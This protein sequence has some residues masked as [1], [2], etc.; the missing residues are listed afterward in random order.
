[1]PY[2]LQKMSWQSLLH[3]KMNLNISNF[4]KRI[5]LILGTEKPYIIL[6][7]T[8]IGGRVETTQYVTMAI[9]SSATFS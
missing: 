3:G 9:Q 6:V 5:Y 2:F 4:F 1:M 8:V 7:W